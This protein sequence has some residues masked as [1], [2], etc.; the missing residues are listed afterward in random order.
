[1]QD[2]PISEQELERYVAT[3]NFEAFPKQA[4]AA[5]RASTADVREKWLKARYRALKSHLYLGGY[6]D[7]IKVMD[8]VRDIEPDAEPTAPQIFQQVPLMGWDFQPE[9]HA[10]LFQQFLQKRPGEGIA[11]CDLDTKIRKRMILWPRNVFKTSAVI[12]DI[13]QTILNYPNVRI[14][15][16]TGT[17]DLAKR[18]LERVKKVFKEPTPM[19]QYLFPEFCLKSVPD[20]RKIGKNGKASDGSA[21]VPYIDAAPKWGTAHEF[22]V[23]ARTATNY[24]EP[25]FAITTAR[26]VKAGSHFDVAY[27]DDLVNEQNYRSVKALEKC[28]TDY[29][30]TIPLLD[31][32]TGQIVMTGTRYSFGDTYERIKELADEENANHGRSVWLFSIRDCWAYGCDHCPHTNVYHDFTV[33]VVQGPCTAPGCTCPGYH[34]SNAT[35]DVLFP[36]ARTRNGNS[37][38]GDLETLERTKRELGPE[39]FSCQYENNPLAA[40]SQTF[41]HELI[42]AQTLHD[43][44]LIPSYIDSTTIAVADLAYVGQEG[45]DYS[46]IFLCRIYRGQIFVY[47]CLYGNWNAS[48]VAENMYK[49]MMCER[50]SV[51]YIEKTNSYDAY[52]TVINAYCNARNMMKVPIQWEKGSQADKA[53]LTRIGSIRGVLSERRLWFYINMGLKYGCAC[54]DLLVNQLVKW[55]KLGRHDD[56]ADCM[57]MVVSAPTGYQLTNPPAP[58]SGTNWLIRLQ[59]SDT[60]EEPDTRLPGSYDPNDPYNRWK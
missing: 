13:V 4:A 22:T 58:V 15:F 50:P 48:Q 57:G 40:E 44:R 27:I 8:P 36:L 19:F 11:F 9:P 5:I 53:K 43:E 7:D 31:P 6:I 34:K 41:T 14:V 33:N 47:D 12:V 2:I 23:P 59:G 55:P 20:K 42:V 25:T 21:E 35:K 24:A 26:S 45:R 38:G 30:S 18:Q 56:F 17:D 51:I 32:L 1:M 54:Y 46:V 16:Q 39:F 10:L 28:Y 3:I 52:N 37:I 49:V 29:L 60:S